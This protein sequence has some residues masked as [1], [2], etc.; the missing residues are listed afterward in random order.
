MLL[1]S[2]FIVFGHSM[3]PNILRGQTVLVS[4]IPYLFSKPKIND[5]V[6][7]IPH[8]NGTGFKEKNTGKIFIKRIVKNN[9]NKYFMKG[10]NKKDSVDSQEIGWVL[11]KEIVG[12][13]IFKI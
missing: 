6:A 12:K 7:F 2:R 11:R 5:I 8:R 1:L 3:E 9:G 4:L 10:D 13:V